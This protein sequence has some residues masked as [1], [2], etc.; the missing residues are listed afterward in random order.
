MGDNMEQ[1]ILRRKAKNLCNGTEAVKVA[2]EGKIKIP[3]NTY[4][5]MV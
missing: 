5:F 1:P 2:V 3:L 4:G